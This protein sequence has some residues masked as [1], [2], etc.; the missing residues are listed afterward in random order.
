MQAR[1]VPVISAE[2]AGELV[3]QGILDDELLI[4][5]HPVAADLV[6]QHGADRQAFLEHQL[7][8]GVAT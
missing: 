2:E 7:E 3:V 6:R 8:R 1:Q 4:L 5:T